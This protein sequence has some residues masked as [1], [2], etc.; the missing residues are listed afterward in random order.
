MANEAAP[1]QLLDVFRTAALS[2]TKLYKSS[3]TAQAKARA[4]G[5]QDCLDDLLQFLDREN[6]GVGD[7]EGWKIRGWANDRLDNRDVSPQMLDSDD[8][9]E[10]PEPMV[11]SPEVHAPSGATPI[12]QGMHHQRQ[13]QMQQQQHPSP[14]VATT[15]TAS[16]P[17]TEIQAEAEEDTPIVEEITPDEPENFAVP[18]Q[19]T[20]DFRS[21]NQLNFGSLRLSD[22]G[23]MNHNNSSSPSISRSSRSTRHHSANGGR[24]NVRMAGHTSGPL[25]RGAGTKRQLNYEELFGL[26][27]LGQ[28]KD[29]LGAPG[30][31]RRHI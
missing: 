13:Q 5:Y 14:A 21:Q 9:A 31:K 27:G 7:G 19:D 1:E 22:N 23:N 15:T 30:S 24:R 2:V 28:S 29:G 6:L 3:I 18:S 20:F 25:G 11:T 8:D 4:E 17:T 26:P 12:Q 16:D 10:K